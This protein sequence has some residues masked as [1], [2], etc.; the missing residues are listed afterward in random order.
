M[1]EGL[2]ACLIIDEERTL[3]TKFYQY[4][5]YHRNF[6]FYFLWTSH[7]TEEGLIGF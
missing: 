4:R 3:I 6:I 1:F 5:L 2:I 7:F